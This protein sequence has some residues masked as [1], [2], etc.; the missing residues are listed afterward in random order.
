MQLDCEL[1]TPHAA[2]DTEVWF[3]GG[4]R[5]AAASVAGE[6]AKA[7]CQIHFFPKAG[8]SLRGN[9][10]ASVFPLDIEIVEDAGFS[11]SQVRT[12]GWTNANPLLNA[13]LF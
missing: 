12:S 6:P 4:G 7:G 8:G 2:D 11:E 3:A 10:L 13:V 1:R 9:Q 5:P